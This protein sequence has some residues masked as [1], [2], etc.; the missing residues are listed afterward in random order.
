[1]KREEKP[2]S[3]FV[4]LSKRCQLLNWT[5]VGRLKQAVLG[6]TKTNWTFSNRTKWWKW[7]K[8]I[9]RPKERSKR[10]SH[11]GRKYLWCIFFLSGTKVQLQSWI[12][13][14]H[15]PWLRILLFWS[16][17]I[18]IIIL[19]F[20]IIQSLTIATYALSKQIQVADHWR[21]RS[22]TRK[23]RESAIRFILWF[24]WISQC[25]TGHGIFVSTYNTIYND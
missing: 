13:M 9:K 10:I 7:P 17:I 23:T 8:R 5:R 3:K 18:L 19:R 6:R 24:I 15:G 11:F 22:W 4:K 25:A 12:P 14:C 20:K 1:M 2:F 16:L 21:S